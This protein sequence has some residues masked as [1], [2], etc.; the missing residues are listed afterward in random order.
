MP[1]I[2]SVNIAHTNRWS[3]LLGLYDVEVRVLGTSVA[4]V[5]GAGSLGVLQ[6]VRE[7]NKKINSI[8]TVLS[9]GR[10]CDFN[11]TCRVIVC[12]EH[13]N[14]NSLSFSGSPLIKSLARNSELNF[15]SYS[16]GPITIGGGCVFGLNS[17]LVSGVTLGDRVM[18]GAGSVVSTQTPVA[19]RSVLA[20][21]PAKLISIQPEKSNL[22]DFHKLNPIQVFEAFSANSASPDFSDIE[23]MPIKQRLVVIDMKMSANKIQ[24]LSVAGLRSNN[25]FMQLSS[26]ST[27]VRAFFEQINMKDENINIDLDIFRDFLR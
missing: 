23:P 19:D 14:P 21:N 26:L 7:V 15:I 11:S 10:Y 24:G 12:G 6:T 16:K 1:K 8:G 9:V 4:F 2:V 20:G 25:E 5:V 18:V 27:G 3:A 22:Y 13:R 17:I